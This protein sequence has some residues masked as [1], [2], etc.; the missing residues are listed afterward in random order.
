MLLDKCSLSYRSLSLTKRRRTITYLQRSVSEDFT[1]SHVLCLKQWWNGYIIY[2]TL[3]FVACFPYPRSSCTF[4]TTPNQVY[5]K[6]K[7]AQSLESFRLYACSGEYDLN[8]TY[9]VE[10]WQTCHL[11][12]IRHSCQT[13]FS[14]WSANILHDH[15]WL[16][17]S[18]PPTRL[19]TELIIVKAL[20]DS[21]VTRCPNEWPC[22]LHLMSRGWKPRKNG[23]VNNEAFLTT[24]TPDKRAVDEQ[25]CSSKHPFPNDANLGW[26]N[27][28]RE[29]PDPH[30]TESFTS[31]E[32]FGRRLSLGHERGLDDPTSL[33][34]HEPA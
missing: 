16:S 18:G 7:Q 14:V 30:T 23:L 8:R 28:V 6:P 24:I 26:F 10:V 20:N 3:L 19:P 5:G 29:L 27:T 25:R 32:A 33:L 31:R 34:T 17:L 1:R 2:L 9:S 11:D 13:S 12:D 4:S 22:L 15:F 21:A